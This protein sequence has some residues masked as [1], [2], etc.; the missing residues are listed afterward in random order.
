MLILSSTFF[1]IRY[2]F[3]TAVLLSLSTNS[4]IC[5]ISGS[6]SIVWFSCITMGCFPAFLNHWFFFFFLPRCMAC[7]TLVPRPGIEPAPLAV[8]AWSPNHWTAR[9]FTSDSFY[10]RC[11][12]L[13][14]LHLGAEFL[15][16]PLNIF[17]F[18]VGMQLSYL[19]IVCNFFSRLAFKFCQWGPKQPL[20]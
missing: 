11:Q 8:K 17:G 2:I 6:V 12:T 13:W 9:E 1:N 18:S 19:E 5:V 16:I 20:V 14:I 15:C 4:I 10:I 7:G 3:L